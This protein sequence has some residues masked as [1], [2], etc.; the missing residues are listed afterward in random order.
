MLGRFGPK[1][2]RQQLLLGRLVDIGAE[3]YAMSAS[4]SRA[5]H[6]L[7]SEEECDHVLELA[8]Y[9]CK[10]GVRRVKSLFLEARKAPDIEGYKLAQSLLF[11]L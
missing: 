1:L 5:Q 3:L 8:R 6:L 11:D 7:G 2:D 10:R 4:C 9:I